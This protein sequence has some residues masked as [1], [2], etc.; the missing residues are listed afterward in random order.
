M[1]FHIL[2]KA[3]VGIPEREI[4]WNIYIK[5]EVNFTLAEVFSTQNSFHHNQYRIYIENGIISIKSG[6]KSILYF[7]EYSHWSLLNRYHWLHAR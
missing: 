6:F 5:F 1:F 7:T 2:D 4:L 3:A